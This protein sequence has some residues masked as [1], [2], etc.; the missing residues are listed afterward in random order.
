MR[1]SRTPTTPTLLPP[2]NPRLVPPL[3]SKKGPLV[4]QQP[5][6]F[7]LAVRQ[8]WIACPSAFNAASWII[9]LNVGCAWIVP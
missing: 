7:T 6:G 3:Q 1:S 5:L 4:T 2:Q 9:S 8:I